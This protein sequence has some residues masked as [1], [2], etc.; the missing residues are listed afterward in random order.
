M[1]VEAQLKAFRTVYGYLLTHIAVEAK[2]ING[3]TNK[4]SLSPWVTHKPDGTGTISDSSVFKQ[5]VVE[6]K[7]EQLH[8]ESF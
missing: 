8:E 7:T 2:S 4:W 6:A 3:C 5:V 1:D